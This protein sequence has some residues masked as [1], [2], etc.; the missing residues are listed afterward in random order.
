M[1]DIAKHSRY[2]V[3]GTLGKNYI[4]FYVSFNVDIAR[5]SYADIYNSVTSKYNNDTILNK[6]SGN[7]IR[8]LCF[9]RDIIQIFVY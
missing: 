5:C 7:A 6:S 1:S 9:I 8:E 2:M 4:F 3:N